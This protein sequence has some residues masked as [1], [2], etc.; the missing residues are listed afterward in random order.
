MS[1]HISKTKK[2]L[3]QACSCIL[4]VSGVQHLLVMD[5]AA[6]M[7]CPHFLGSHAY[8]DFKSWKLPS[9]KSSCIPFFSFKCSTLDTW[10]CPSKS[11]ILLFSKQIFP[12]NQTF[13]YSPQSISELFFFFLFHII[14][15][16]PALPNTHP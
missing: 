8:K 5:T 16:R 4:E 10:C 12:A 2:G 6:Q 11:L 14:N 1:H 9:F 13:N 7:N 15:G 3:G